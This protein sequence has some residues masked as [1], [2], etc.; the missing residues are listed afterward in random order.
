MVTVPVVAVCG[1]FVIVQTWLGIGVFELAI[2][3]ILFGITESG[4]AVKPRVIP[5][6]FTG[7][8]IVL[9]VV[10]AQLLFLKAVRQTL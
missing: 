2:N 10:E 9:Q 8:Y 6:Q 1:N 7:M 5:L 3:F 4:T